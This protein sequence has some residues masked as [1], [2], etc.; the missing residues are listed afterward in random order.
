MFTKRPVKSGKR[1]GAK[2]ESVSATQ[3]T[4][5]SLAEQMKNCRPVRW[6]L[7]KHLT[8]ESIQM[9]CKDTTRYSFTL[10]IVKMQIKTTMDDSVHPPDWLKLKMH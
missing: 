2:W 9:A 4:K 5:G 10:V 6:D 3:S 8:K 7:H 1:Q